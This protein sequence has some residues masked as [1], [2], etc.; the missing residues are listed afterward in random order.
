MV[1]FEYKEKYLKYKKKYLELKNMHGG[2]AFSGTPAILPDA[3]SVS[4][5]TFFNSTGYRNDIQ[6]IGN[7]GSRDDFVLNCMY[8]SIH[9]YLIN[10]YKGTEEVPLTLNDLRVKANIRGFKE[11][12]EWDSE[13]SEHVM[14]LHKLARVYNLDIRIWDFDSEQGGLNIFYMDHEQEG[15]SRG[16]APQERFGIGNMH[17]VNILSIGRHFE[18]IVGGNIFSHIVRVTR[19]VMYPIKIN[20]YTKGS[21][22]KD[23]RTHEVSRKSKHGNL[24]HKDRNLERAMH[25]SEMSKEDRDLKRAMH[26]SEMSEEDRDLEFAIQLSIEDKKHSDYKSA[27]ELTEYNK[28]KSAARINK[29]IEQLASHDPRST[30]LQGSRTPGSPGSSAR[31][32]Y[33]PRATESRGSSSRGSHGSRT[34]EPQGGEAE[35][36]HRRDHGLQV[37]DR[38]KQDLRVQQGIYNEKRAAASRAYQV[39]EEEERRRKKELKKP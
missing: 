34:T 1:N 31:G 30:G 16:I 20:T 13:N 9:D 10:Y 24:S 39:R 38:R 29:Y 25:L 19:K 2:A 26:L 12:E 37:L 5:S 14:S 21:S 28:G 6:T 15:E 27:M 17:V 36:S 7:G 23:R 35:D 11:N 3:S 4:G 22:H 32:S 33:D 18:L 8:I